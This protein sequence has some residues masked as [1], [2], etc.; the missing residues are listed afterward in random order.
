MKKTEI[1][2]FFD[3]EDFTSETCADATLHL[4][5]ILSSEGIIGHFSVVALLAEQFTNWNRPD[6]INA[7]KP[8]IIGTHTYGHTLHPN[9]VED[10]EGEDFNTA[11][12]R[13]MEKE[14]LALEMLKKH[15]GTD[16][17]LFA[18]PPGDSNSYAAMYCYNELNIPFYCGSVVHDSR[19][20]LV[21]YSG[22]THIAYIDGLEDM[23]LYGDPRDNQDILES[24]QS[25]D[26]AIIY[27][28]PNITVK[29]VFWDA[30]NYAHGN[31]REY[32][33]WIEA[34]DRSVE[35]IQYLRDRFRGLIRALK[36]DERFEITDLRTLKQQLD[37]KPPRILHRSDL[38]AIRRELDQN[39]YPPRDGRYSIAEVF[40]A[41]TAFLQG[42][43]EYDPA[44]QTL[45]GF[46]S[47]PHGIC[48][49]TDVSKKDI[50]AAAA[51]FD[52]N[53]FIPSEF[54]IGKQKIGPADLL[55]AMLEVLTT[56]HETIRLIP[57]EQNVMCP[58]F[59]DLCNFDLKDAWM[60]VKEFRDEYVS[61]R[62]RLQSW[63]LRYCGI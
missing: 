43:T 3:T 37:A 40:H 53:N 1:L 29:K 49:P 47:V 16:E 44:A 10:S 24:L 48:Q 13:V 34:E 31:L 12:H 17:I 4:A 22:M 19:N 46:L 63:T 6:V 18:V 60:Y 14:H 25:Y 8:H 21:D 11:Y 51:G 42:S 32:G 57:R 62:L 56:D 7:L 52:K 50:L 33:D 5:E 35:E 2:F 20:T 54:V 39:F 28:H 36:E 58:E 15:L 38:P 41:C 23:F 55:F 61:D 9:I 30:L 45:R 59:E 26:R 27:T